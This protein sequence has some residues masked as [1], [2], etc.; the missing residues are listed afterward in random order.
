MSAPS[1]RTERLS[2]DPPG[3]ADFDLYR[4]FYADADGAGN[5]GGPRRPDQAWRRLA[6]DVGRWA[7]RGFGMWTLRRREDGE[8]VGGCGLFHPEGWPSHELTWWL[9]PRWRGAGYAA[10]A[11]RAAIEFG[12]GALGWPSVET[13]MRDENAPARRLAER[14]GGEV[15]RRETF[16]DGVARD[17]FRLPRPDCEERESDA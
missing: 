10:E 3:S 16:P 4:D 2:L 14:L 1:L 9:Q 12:Y 15:V 17:V 6:E 13:H 11:S 5:Y 7:L 8:A